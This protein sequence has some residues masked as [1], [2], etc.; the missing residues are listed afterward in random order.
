[1]PELP[2]ISMLRPVRALRRWNQTL[3]A[4]DA[5]SRSS[6]RILLDLAILGALG[7][8]I[9]G[10]TLWSA[11]W[12]VLTDHPRSFAVTMGAQLALYALAA[13]WVVWRRPPVRG[14]LLIIV[15]VA[16]A[17][18]LAFAPQV[19]SASSDI[20]R[21][22]WDGRVQAQGINPYRYSPADPALEEYRDAAIYDGINRKPVPTI[23][24]PVAQ[25][26][27]RA[28]YQIYPDSVTWTKVALSGFDLATIVVLAGLLVRLRMR[29]DRVVLYAWH[30]LL[31]LELGHSGH[32]DV[33]AVTFLALAL[34][35]RLADRP[36]L[37]GVLLACAAL[38]KFYAIVALPALLW[39]GGWRSWRRDLRLGLACAVTVALAYLPFLSVGSKVFGYLF[40]YVEE[41]GFASGGRFYLLRRVHELAARWSIGL[42]EWLVAVSIDSLRLYLIVFVGVMG[43]LALWCWWR[44]LRAAREIPGRALLLFF[45]L[46]MLAS[47]TYPWYMLLV[48]VF[49]PFVGWRLLVP[50]SVLAG[51]MGFHY[52]QWWDG[53]LPLP[54]DFAYGGG[55]LALAGVGLA[56]GLRTI[57]GRIHWSALPVPSQRMGIVAFGPQFLSPSRDAQHEGE[58]PSLFDRFPWFYAFCRDRLFRDHTERVAAA[59]WPGG[60]PRQG[61]SLLEI[62]CGPGFYAH[63]FAA[64]FPQ[65]HVVGVDRSAAQLRLASAAARDL[66]NCHFVRGDAR[67]L[68]QPA[69]SVGLIVASRLFTI[70]PEQER[71]LAEMYRVLEPGGCCFIAEPRSRLWTAVPLGALWGLARLARL[72]GRGSRAYREPGRATVLSVEAF[73]ALV[74][75]QPWAEA[76]QLRDRQYHYAVCR[77]A[78][79]Q[80]EA[81]MANEALAAD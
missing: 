74:E 40:G 56:M 76:Q 50:A 60:A 37:T 58:P 9:V 30:P 36:V 77:K 4:L 51:L 52:L 71:A 18:R 70:V 5:S 33:V 67:S 35:A 15:L 69:N 63:R 44:P 79:R 48:L 54:L 42:P 59:F 26:V 8:G 65:L 17:A 53:P 28:I 16:L 68:S 29:P 20:Y 38:T 49:V 80:R 10:L 23:Y 64:R 66:V 46:L 81:R 14:A 22:V 61:A 41:E 55:V 47:P 57:W 21:Y 1:M 75:S 32:I 39:A 19:P 7:A 45:A 6:G 34:W 13:L 3:A 27:F 31:I 43:T 72:T 11:H 2:T 73:A 12:R 62:G 25:T 24:P 78:V